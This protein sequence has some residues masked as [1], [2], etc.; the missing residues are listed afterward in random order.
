MQLD[1]KRYFRQEFKMYLIRTTNLLSNNTTMRIEDFFEIPL[2]M[3][4]MYLESFFRKNKII[5]KVI[6]RNGYF[7][8]EIKGKIFIRRCF[9]DED[10]ALRTVLQKAIDELEE[11]HLQVYRLNS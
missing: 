7:F 6:E 5:I 9:Q 8:P 2:K 4:F 1:P 11:R 3:Q 10:E